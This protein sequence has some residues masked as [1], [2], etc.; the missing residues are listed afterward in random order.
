VVGEEGSL[1]V[2]DPWHIRSPRI[3]LR[4]EEGVED[5]SVEPA[6]SYRLELENVCDAIRGTAPLLLGREDAVGQARTL[7]AL[8][9]SAEA[10]ASVPA[11]DWST[12]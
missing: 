5:I 9:R 12:R 11:G 7:D 3:E 6:N 10:A 4:R 2:E 8:Y 1:H